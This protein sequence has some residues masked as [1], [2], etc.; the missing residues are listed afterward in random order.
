MET[1]QPVI[2]YKNI[3]VGDKTIQLSPNSVVVFVGPNNVG[4]TTALKEL[5]N[6]IRSGKLSHNGRMNTIVKAA[7]TYQPANAEEVTEWINLHIDER[8]PDQTSMQNSRTFRNGNASQI[9]TIE[10]FK[11]SVLNKEQWPMV[12]SFLVGS[13]QASSVQFEGA[14]PNFFATGTEGSNKHFE[15]LYNSAELESEISNLCREAFKTPVMMSRYGSQA[16]LHYGELP[17]FSNPLTSDDRTRLHAAPKISNQGQGVQQLLSLGYNMLIGKEPVVFLDEPEAHLHPPQA[18]LAGKCIAKRASK[19]QVFLT[20]HSVDLILGL[21][22][23]ECNVSIIRID[24]TDENKSN[25]AVLSGEDLLAAWRDPFVRYSNA[26]TGLMHKGVIICEADGDCLYY[27]V[28]LEYLR[29]EN[30]EPNHDLL[31]LQSGGKAGAKKIIPSLRSLAVPISVICDF[32]MLR[33]WNELSGLYEALG[34][35]PSNI[36]AKWR[37]IKEHIDQ[38]NDPR[39]VAQVKEEIKVVIDSY[40]IGDPY[41]KEIKSQLQSVL[42]IRDG[43]G[44]AKRQGITMLRSTILTAATE[45]IEELSGYGV[46][47][48]PF[49]E[50]ESFHP[51]ASTSSHGDKW[52]ME[53]IESE[54]YK[55]L[56]TDKQHFIKSIPELCKSRI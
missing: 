24:R 48:V 54:R 51:E 33:N 49:G 22:E 25:A 15:E 14:A 13:D 34:G 39:T 44:D 41:I 1:S 6:N 36:E 53:A 2:H 42:G 26:L 7:E 50:I 56:H 20:T 28:A 23:S 35:N 52:V 46:I 5:E 4:K 19:S 43:W 32:D 9:M 31:F 27:Q 29:Q 37:M 12:H 8:L 21:L 40:Q 18:K 47:I 16:V 38:R 45:L 30:R 3:K 11:N 17:E 55:T 10:G